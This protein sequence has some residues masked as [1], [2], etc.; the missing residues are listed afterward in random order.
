MAGIAVAFALI[1]EAIAFSMI[2]GVNPMVGLDAAFIISIV[3]SIFGGR[4]GMISGAT[5]R[6]PC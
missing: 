5:G 3:V 6:L 2:A 1:P 4:V